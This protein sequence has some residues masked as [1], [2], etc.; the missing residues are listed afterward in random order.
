MNTLPQQEQTATTLYYIGD[1]SQKE[2]ADY[3]NVPVTTVKARLRSARKKL[4]E[5]ILDMVEDTLHEKAP[6]RDES[7]VNKIGMVNAIL[8]GDTGRVAYIIKQQ[9]D[10]ATEDINERRPIHHAAIH[11][12]TTI[13]RLLL[14][15]GADPAV[16]FYP[17]RATTSALELARERG[18]NEIVEMIQAHLKAAFSYCEV[19]S[20]IFDLIE[21][22]RFDQFIGLLKVDPASAR[23]AEADGTTPLHEVVRHQRV[24]MVQP[25]L[26]HGA[27]VDAAN[28]RGARPIHLAMEIGNDLMTGLLIGK[29]AEYELGVAASCG[30]TTRVK[31]VLDKTPALANWADSNGFHAITRA[32]QNGHVETVRV[33][34]DH[35]VTCA[36]PLET[37]DTK[38]IFT[39][40]S[41]AAGK[42]HLEIVRLLLDHGVDVDE[43][44]YYRTGWAYVEGGLGK[45][46]GEP[47]WK[48][49]RQG[50]PG[51]ARL[52]LERGSTPDE[53]LPASGR[54]IDCAAWNDDLEM[55]ELLTGYGAELEL[56]QRL[57]VAQLRG[58]DEHIIMKDYLA[59]D[60]EVA[61]HWR[62]F[63]TLAA[64]GRA[65]LLIHGLDLLDP[66]EYQKML[67]W[68]SRSVNT[69]YPEEGDKVAVAR[70]LLERGADPQG[71][72]HRLGRGSDYDRY[73]EIADA[74]IDHGANLDERDDVLGLTPLGFG[75]RSNNR[76]F[77]EL[78]LRRGARPNLQDDLPGVTP[79][80]IALNKGFTEMANLFEA[81]GANV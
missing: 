69:I 64:K 2:V 76:P 7:F 20:A 47:L 74:M 4:K 39:T 33:F 67:S 78:L 23:C 55:I 54:P 66:S 57:H 3:L 48:A 41:T 1:F 9:P 26:D 68:S 70:L 63:P 46:V 12:H 72:L 43:T 6:S 61:R 79:L 37:L 65:D 13:V 11:G 62:Y 58:E 50:H 30:D 25:L 36:N 51:I 16:G 14:D 22:D 53:G 77:V 44:K 18:Y 56:D 75:V 29:G 15:A 40:L 5:R 19:R 10:L 17:D 81:H 42:G 71:H 45:T 21:E 28:T 80:A 49:A 52:L 24:G 59:N 32:A 73:L 35:G 60:P 34:M 31:T 38:P 8:A 27:Y